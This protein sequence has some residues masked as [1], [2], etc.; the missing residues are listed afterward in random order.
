MNKKDKNKSEQYGQFCSILPICVLVSILTAVLVTLVFSIAFVRSFKLETKTPLDVSGTFKEALENKEK[1]VNGIT[2][3]GGEAVVDFFTSGKTGFIFASDEGC[4]NCVDF[5]ARLAN[6]AASAEI[7]DI[8]HYEHIT[9]GAGN[10]E[11]T[12]RNV[13]IGKEDSPVL[14]YVREGVVYDRL[15][16]INSDS[17]LSTFLAKYK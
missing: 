10:A 12:A 5:G 16:D 2:L 9:E 11:I 1:D 15:D 8:Y 3:V 7:S 14:V 4:S 17:D 6:V 13:T